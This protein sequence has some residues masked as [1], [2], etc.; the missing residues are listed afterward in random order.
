MMRDSG[1]LLMVLAFSDPTSTYAPCGRNEAEE[2][3]WSAEI[4]S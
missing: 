1:V 4:Q 3:T 2:I